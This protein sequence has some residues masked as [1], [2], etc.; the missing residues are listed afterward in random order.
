MTI[1][2]GSNLRLIG[3]LVVVAVL[4]VQWWQF[5]ARGRG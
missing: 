2:I 5:R 4:V 1:E 3:I